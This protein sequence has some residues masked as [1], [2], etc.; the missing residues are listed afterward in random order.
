MYLDKKKL[1]SYENNKLLLC[2][3]QKG[4]IVE[5]KTDFTE[6]NKINENHD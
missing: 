2:V 3:R 5:N 1:L 4:R 6:F